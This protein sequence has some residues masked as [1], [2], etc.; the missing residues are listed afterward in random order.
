MLYLKSYLVKF[1]YIFSEECQFQIELVI[2]SNIVFS[3]VRAIMRGKPSFLKTIIKNPF[4]KLFAPPEIVDEVNGAIEE[5]LPKKF[6]RNDA[7][8]LA[9]ELISQIEVLEGQR[10]EAWVKSSILIGKRDQKD[11]PFLS[12]AFSLRA[13]GIITK[14]RDFEEQNEVRLWELGETGRMVSDFNKGS[15]SFFLLGTLLPNVLQFC[16][17]LCISFFKFVIEVINGIISVAIALVR[18]GVEGLS[19][20]PPW[21]SITVIGGFAF[22]MIVSEKARKKVGNFFSIL[23]EIALEVY[24]KIKK[25][26]SSI[27]DGIKLFIQFIEP[28]I[29]LVISA[30]GYLFNCAIELIG[31]I[32]ELEESRPN[33]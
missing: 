4:L 17:W 5:D 7:K 20:I 24:S 11:V 16:Y 19:R 6:N 31:K 30:I 18:G 33:I 12:L 27:I 22:T 1:Q 29:I 15:V 13:H 10:L 21:L 14:D 25:V 3:E 8:E 32:E 23:G 9:F 28:F 26:F 2:D